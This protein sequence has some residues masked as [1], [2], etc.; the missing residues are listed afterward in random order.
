[1]HKHP[2]A[3]RHLEAGDE[4]ELLVVV[5]AVEY[6]YV[7]EAPGGERRP[8]RLRQDLTV[9]DARDR[10]ARELVEEDIDR[11]VTQTRRGLVRAARAGRERHTE[12]FGIGA[13]HLVQCERAAL[14]DRP[15]EET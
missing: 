9:D 12:G 1:R 7:R 15:L 6:R 10:S 3:D 13:R 11:Q 14:D 4:E 8:D 5:E 2:P